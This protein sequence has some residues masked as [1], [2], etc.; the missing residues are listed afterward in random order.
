MVSKIIKFI[1]LRIM[2]VNNKTILL[3]RFRNGVWTIPIAT[4]KSGRDHSFYL[5]SI[6]NN[7][8]G[9]FTP[10]KFNHIITSVSKDEEDN[11]TYESTIYDLRYKGV[12][13]PEISR[14]LDDTFVDSK[15]VSPRA[16]ARSYEVNYTTDAIIGHMVE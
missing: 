8:S 10:V 4:M 7:L 12:V 6:C 5:K 9:S 15:W 1:G 13:F 14:A 11:E 2:N 16:A 3:R